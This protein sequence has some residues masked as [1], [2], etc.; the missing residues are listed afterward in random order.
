M[1]KH[2]NVDKAPAAV[3]PYVHAV[4]L[5]NTVFVSGQL[6]IDPETGNL[7][8]GVEEQMI[9][10]MTNVGLILNAADYYYEDIIKT[11]IFLT[12]MNDFAKVNEIYGRFFKEF[13]PARSCIQVGALP[14]GGLVEVEVIAAK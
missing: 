10:A 4:D 6:G 9:Q 13:F 11:T 8:E 12:D 5:G 1:K 2:I 7:K 14:K 3:G